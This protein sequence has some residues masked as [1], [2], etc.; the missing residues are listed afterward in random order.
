[1]RY[2]HK[3]HFLREFLG[4][5]VR[6]LLELYSETLLQRAE[7][8]LLK[9]QAGLESAIDKLR[10]SLMDRSLSESERELTWRRLDRLESLRPM[11]SVAL[12]TKF[13]RI[14][15]GCYDFD[16]SDP[17]KVD[18]KT[19]TNLVAV[20]GDHETHWHLLITYVEQKEETDQRWYHPVEPETV[21]VDPMLDSDDID[22]D[23]L[24]HFQGCKVAPLIQTHVSAYTHVESVNLLV[25]GCLIG[26]PKID[27][28]R[29]LHG[30]VG[31]WT[32]SE[33]RLIDASESYETSHLMFLANSSGC[34][35]SSQILLTIIKNARKKP[36]QSYSEC[37]DTLS[38][39]NMLR[40]SNNS[41]CWLFF[42]NLSSE[43]NDPCWSGVAC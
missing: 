43:R 37:R 35:K 41:S 30:G 42:S 26:M 5:P 19:E 29:M 27:S 10:W 38:K 13:V 12:P 34:L 31:K 9:Q 32:N 17:E 33:R 36:C 21:P 40:H 4:S 3:V 39:V 1:M 28:N 23:G 20:N 2:R 6:D 7:E 15:F 25:C 16:F 8:S 14:R 18:P 24:S 22:D 11:F